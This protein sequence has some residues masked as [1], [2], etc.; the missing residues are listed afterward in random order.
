MLVVLL[1]INLIVFGQNKIN[2]PTR[3]IDGLDTFTVFT[4]QSE[5]IIVYK[6]IDYTF[7]KTE[8]KLANIIIDSCEKVNTAKENYIKLLEAETTNLK[9]QNID[10]DKVA[11]T[12][13]KEAEIKEKDNKKLIKRK[14]GWKLSSVFLASLTTFILIFK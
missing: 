8:L 2:P 11:T 7:C 14:D 3:F 13:K 12:Y 10:K 5:R 1:F 9:A 6:L 4:I